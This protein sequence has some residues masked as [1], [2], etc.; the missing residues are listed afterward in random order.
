MLPRM[1]RLALA[2]LTLLCACGNLT[3]PAIGLPDA[4][5]PLKASA[6][7]AVSSVV[8]LDKDLLGGRGLP[9]VFQALT[10][11]GQ[12]QYNA[13]IGTMSSL[14]LYIR[15]SL[16]DLPGTCVKLAASGSTPGV[17]M[18]DPAGEAG[19]QISTLDIARNVNR[20]LKVNGPALD[21]AAHAGHGYIG[22]LITQ[23]L[24][25]E[26]E[27]LALTGLSATAKF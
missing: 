6:I 8:Y 7:I 5:I 24:P 15:S 4:T 1:K 9:S 21:A 3:T 13:N 19:Q 12:V 14:N 11:N 17:A 25:A 27:S 10:I 22:V 16:S 26:G 20:P 23:G 18:C 2:A